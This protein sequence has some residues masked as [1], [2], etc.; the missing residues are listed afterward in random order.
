MRHLLLILVLLSSPALADSSLP[1]APLA[2]T[3]LPNP[4]QEQAAK[5]LMREIRCVVC[6]GESIAESGAEQA[7][8][9]RAL[10]RERIA[11]GDSPAAIKHWLIDRYGAWISFDPPLSILTVPLWLALGGLCAFAAWLTLGRYKRRGKD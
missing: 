2:N 6:R 9:M 8:D 5:Q 1:P 7:G 10:I 4:A 3:A 11:A